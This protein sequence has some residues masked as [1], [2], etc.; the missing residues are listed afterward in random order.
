MATILDVARRAGVATSTVSHVLNRTRF[1]SPAT[2]RAVQDAVRDVGYTPN[3]L[4]RALARSTTNTIGLAVSGSTNRYFND[5]INAIEEECA[6]FGMMVLLVNTR[7]DPDEELRVVVEL[8]QRRV[9]GIL[10]APSGDPK[11]RALSYLTAN[12][13]PTVLVDRL[14]SPDFNGVGVENE[15]AMATLVDHLVSRGHNRI[16]L[17]AG[18][19]SFRTTQERVEGYRTG[20]RRGGLAIDAA[21]ISVGH[22]DIN[23]ARAAANSMVASRKPP[24]AFIGGNNLT[25]LGIMSALSD[26]HLAVP[27]DIAL[28]GFD[29][30]EWSDY[31]KPRLTVMA[32]PCQDIGRNA[33]LRLKSLIEQPLQAIVQQRL[34]PTLRV[35]DSC[36]STS[37]SDGRATP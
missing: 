9:D 30:F 18:Q 37:C 31:F 13:I 32:Q 26:R 20:L 24:T 23:G 8:H 29:D 7:D 2:T 28:V 25:T 4:A 16:G 11:E 5:I 19:A 27:D 34:P 22:A 14:S 33:A 6:Q 12:A 10:F 36:G 15:Q 1:V 3:I 35:R 21:I 17:I